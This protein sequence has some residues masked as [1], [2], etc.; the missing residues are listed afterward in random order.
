[1]KIRRLFSSRYMWTD[2]RDKA[3]GCIESTS[4]QTL[5]KLLT[6]V[7]VESSVFL[8]TMSCSP[9]KVNRRFGDTAA[10]TKNHILGYEAMSYD[11]SSPTFPSKGSIV[12]KAL[13]CKPEGRGFKSR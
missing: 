11:K 5:H 3:E 10:I 2:R 7:V 13:C 4:L 6:A 12:V 9:L 8:D 1:M